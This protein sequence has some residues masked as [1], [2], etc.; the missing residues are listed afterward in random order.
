MSLLDTEKEFMIELNEDIYEN[1]NILKSKFKYC[2]VDFCIINIHN[3]YCFYLEYKKR[4]YVR[5]YTHYDSYYISETK[6][7]E[8][9]KNYNNCIFIWD[10]RNDKC[11]DFFWIKFDNSFFDKYS[12]SYDKKNCSWRYEIL[13]N[14][15]NCGYDKFVDYINNITNRKIGDNKY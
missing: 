10:F 5:N 2:N 13:S 6:L 14:D 15:C 7:N 9:S 8:V 12:K 4:E 11:N 1:Y 3:L